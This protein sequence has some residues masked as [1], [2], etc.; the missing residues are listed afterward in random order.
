MDMAIKKTNELSSEELTR[1]FIERVKVFVVEQNCA[2]QEVDEEDFDAR[3]VIVRDGE[4]IAAYAR[5]LEDEEAIRIGR[6]LV[7]K[8]YRG[9]GLSTKMLQFILKKLIILN[10]YVYLLKLISNTCM[11]QLVLKLSQLNILK[12]IFHMWIWNLSK[13]TNSLLTLKGLLWI[14]F[15][16]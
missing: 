3:H 4:N 6:V 14:L 11:S 5:L 7:V 1:I 15:Q 9:S 2:Y 13:L 12:M 8:D 10:R 16:I